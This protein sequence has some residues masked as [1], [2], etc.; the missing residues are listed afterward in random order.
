MEDFFYQISLLNYHILK[1]MNIKHT[2]FLKH[3]YLFLLKV[4]FLAKK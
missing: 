1:P 2:H 4:A 3:D